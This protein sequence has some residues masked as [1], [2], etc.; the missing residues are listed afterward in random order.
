MWPGQIIEPVSQFAHL[1]SEDG[2][3]A[4]RFIRSRYAHLSCIR[5]KLMYTFKTAQVFN[6]V[7]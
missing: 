6:I 4:S 2:D 1:L 7:R 5:L 3:I